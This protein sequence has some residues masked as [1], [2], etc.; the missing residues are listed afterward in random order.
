MAS[1]FSFGK[2]PG[3]SSITPAAPIIRREIRTVAKPKSQVSPVKP[4]SNGR[5][6][7]QTSR[8]TASTQTPKKT[9]QRK[10]DNSRVTAVR[11][12]TKR[13]SS[14]PSIQ[15]FDSS[16]SASESGDGGL[17]SNA[18]KRTKTGTALKPLFMRC[19]RDVKNWEKQRPG[20]S[21]FVQGIDLTSGE[22]AKGYKAAF[23]ICE[24]SL[25]V[26]LQYPSPGQVER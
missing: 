24:E 6:I 10:A 3:S 9:L 13:K 15:L 2:P 16:S 12:G 8:I 21:K 19:I 14:S 23:G 25:E 17:K 26:E 20:P 5:S 18:R 11:A 22:H 1:F 4:S 7:S